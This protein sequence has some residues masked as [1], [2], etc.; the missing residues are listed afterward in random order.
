MKRASA[1]RWIIG[2]MAIFGLTIIG[3]GPPSRERARDNAA[4]ELCQRFEECGRIGTGDGD[5]HATIDDCLIDRRDEFNSLLPTEDCSNGEIN[6]LQ[7]EECL[8]TIREQSCDNDLGALFDFFEV[9]A[10]CSASD[11]CVD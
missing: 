1:N 5:L 9:R 10:E 4:E 2:T 3:C 8:T 11:V 6:E 7:Y